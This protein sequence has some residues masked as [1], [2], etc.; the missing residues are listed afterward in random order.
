MG[1]IE[2]LRAGPLTTVQDLGRPNFRREGISPGG[3]LD[4]HAARIANLLVGNRDDAAVLEITYGPFRACISDE[5]IIAWCGA[6]LG[7]K[8]FSPGRPIRISANEELNFAAPA[9]GCRRWLAISGG[10]DSPLVLGSRATD[11]RGGFG[12]LDGRAVRDGDR[13]PLG[14]SVELAH[15]SESRASWSAPN[16]W[17]QTAPAHPVLRLVVG[18][19]WDAFTRAARAA[20]AEETY[21]VHADSDRMGA[22]LTGALLPRKKKTEMIS[23]AVAPGTIQVPDGAQPILLLGDCQTLGGYP[24]IAHVI[25]VDLPVAAQLRPN[26][27]VR[28]QIVSLESARE[29]FLSRQNDLERFRAGLQL[30]LP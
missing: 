16:E 21:L 9:R 11:L 28:F 12:G 20:L 13:L 1:E 23:E 15:F 26:D 4:S 18:S 6:T 14:E 17:S 25:T 27:R 22:R 24:K 3:A 30:R 7:E 19:E 5:R 8:E 29:L 2:I 10:I